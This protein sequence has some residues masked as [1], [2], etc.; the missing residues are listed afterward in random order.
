[1]H[2]LFCQFLLCK[3]KNIFCASIGENEK[4]QE[5][6]KP[7]NSRIG[8]KNESDTIE[9]INVLM[10]SLMQENYNN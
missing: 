1:M 4:K 8:F 2:V 5:K 3:K 7:E 6:I 10:K 9:N